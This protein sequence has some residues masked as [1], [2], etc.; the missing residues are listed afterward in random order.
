MI[1]V[2]AVAIVACFAAMLPGHAAAGKSI[3][4]SARTHHGHHRLLA[5]RIRQPKYSQFVACDDRGCSD[6]PGAGFKEATRSAISEPYER[7][8][9]NGTII[10][11]RPSGCPYRFCGCEASLYVFHRII[12]ELNLAYNWIRKFQRAS[13]AP[14]MAAARSGHVMI[15]ISHAGGSDWLVHDGNSG[16]G[17]TRERVQSIA[18][19]VIVNPNAQIAAR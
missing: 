7:A 14:G 4:L 19:Y 3:E 10:G 9:G 13:P 6:R 12:P 17:K 11:S 1:R 15:L 2:L 18:R 16:G 5:H 8:S